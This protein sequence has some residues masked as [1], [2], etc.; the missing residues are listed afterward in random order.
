MAE[1]RIAQRPDELVKPEVALSMSGQEFMERMLAGE[2]P[3]PPISEH[4][5]MLLTKVEAGR[6]IFEGTPMFAA[7]N[8]MGTLHGGWYGT[9][10][11]SAMACAVM[12]AL[13][14]GQY[15]TTLEYK[16]NIIRSIP[17]GMAVTCEG[18]ADHVGRSTGIAHGEVRG[19]EDGKLYATGSTTCMVMRA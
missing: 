17:A 15:Y 6:V 11:D 10:L 19:T 14:R 16:V 12:S 5:N 3:A 2:F 1:R 7:F 13:D 18:I 9:I 8:P 4:M